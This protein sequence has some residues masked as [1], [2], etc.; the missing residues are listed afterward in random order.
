MFEEEISVVEPMDESQLWKDDKSDLTTAGAISLF[1]SSLNKALQR[2]RHSEI[3]SEFKKI[4]VS[5]VNTNT[6][7]FI[8]GQ[9]ST[10]ASQPPSFEFKQE[11]IKIQFR[12]NTDRISSLRRTG[13]SLSSESLDQT[14][15]LKSMVKTEL[16]TLNQRNKYLKIA[17]RHWWDTDH[18]YLDDL[19]AE[20]VESA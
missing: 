5:S 17:K 6:H 13:H 11:G 4:Q 2:Q 14:L 1:H 8:N 10:N 16:D 9:A 19:L 20:S 15:D 7:T 3:L 18:E 12:Y